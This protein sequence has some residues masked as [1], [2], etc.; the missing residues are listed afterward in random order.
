MGVIKNPK[1]IYKKKIDCEYYSNLSKLAKKIGMNI[2]TFN[3]TRDYN[4]DSKILVKELKEIKK[5]G[6]ELAKGIVSENKIEGKQSLEEELHNIKSN[7]EIK[8]LLS[9]IGINYKP[10]KKNLETYLNINNSERFSPKTKNYQTKVSKDID[11]LD[12][13]N[14]GYFIFLK[15]IEEYLNGKDFKR[16]D[17]EPTLQ[18]YS[19]PW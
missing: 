11:T 2:S 16:K 3:G 9:S 14:S 17:R 18:K 8:S 10:T 1:D 19:T 6:Y 5:A 4:P 7:D 15:G 12:I 13:I